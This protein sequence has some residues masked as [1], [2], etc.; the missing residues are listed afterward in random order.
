MVQ[1]LKYTRWSKGLTLVD[2]EGRSSRGR[3]EIVQSEQGCLECEV[4]DVKGVLLER[5]GST[6]MAAVVV[7]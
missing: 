5:L 2:L 4:Q 3:D 6:R 1:S 7:E